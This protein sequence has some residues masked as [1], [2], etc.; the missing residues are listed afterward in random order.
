[1]DAELRAAGLATGGFYATA[2]RKGDRA[3]YGQA[4]TDA[5]RLGAAPA[6]ELLEDLVGRTRRQARPEVGNL[7]RGSVAI[8]VGAHGDRTAGRRVLRRV[9]D[10]VDEQLLEQDRIDVGE[11]VR[12]LE[13]E[14]MIGKLAVEP[15]ERGA[16]KLVERHPLAFRLR[17]G[18]DLRDR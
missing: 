16:D 12:D 9:L 2:V 13:R 4:E 7:D 15:C 14:R 3:T 1:P 8:A 17:T 6:E 10:E 11:L 18:L 5:G